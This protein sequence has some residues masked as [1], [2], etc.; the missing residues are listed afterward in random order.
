MINLVHVNSNAQLPVTI[1]W[2]STV[3][4][5]FGNG[6]AEI[7]PPLSVGHTDFTF[8]GT[9]S[10][11]AG[12]YS[13]IRSSNDAGHLFF[14]PFP[15]TQPEVGYKMI[16][17]YSS[18][19]CPKILFSDTVR[20]LCRSSTYLFWA[21]IDNVLPTSSPGSGC[22]CMDAEIYRCPPQ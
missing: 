9:L 15:M 16:G 2:S 8:S 3:N 19:I 4:A 11:A 12:T 22:I 6:Q 21:G 13:V 18:S 7:G 1:P 10:P 20:N 5:S 14:G 17:S